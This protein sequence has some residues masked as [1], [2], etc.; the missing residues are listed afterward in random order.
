MHSWASAS[1]SIPPASAF[2]NPVFQSDI[3]ALSSFLL[4]Q[5]SFFHS[6]LAGRNITFVRRGR[7]YVQGAIF[8]SFSQWHFGVHW[9]GECAG[10]N[11]AMYQ[12]FR[13]RLFEGWGRRA[14]NLDHATSV[15]QP[16]RSLALLYHSKR[17][18]LSCS[19]I[20][21]L[22]RYCAPCTVTYFTTF[23]YSLAR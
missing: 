15:Y 4:Q 11:Q 6:L 5:R 7:T 2:R 14:R 21:T 8:C 20:T 10:E 17:Q 9:V 12:W 18:K 13:A 1:R 3:G 23:W 16:L 19:Y 22:K